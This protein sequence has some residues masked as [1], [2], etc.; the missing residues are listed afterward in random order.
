MKTLKQKYKL[1]TIAHRLSWSVVIQAV[2]FLIHFQGIAQGVPKAYE[3]VNYS[4]KVNGQTVRLI[5][6][7]G[8]IGASSL[9]LSIPGNHK[10]IV[11]QADQG[12]GAQENRVKFVNE[13]KGRHDYFVMDNMQ[14]SY[15]ENPEYLNGKYYL[16][17]RVFPV[18][19]LLIRHSHLNH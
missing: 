4:G 14:D 15:D 19:F 8:Y 3:P 6:A 18:K 2:F 11:F 10:P 12:V 7:N 9:K 17:H 1:T 16:N 5:L 13:L